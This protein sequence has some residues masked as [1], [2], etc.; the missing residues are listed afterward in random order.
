M[1]VIYSLRHLPRPPQGRFSYRY[2][3][4]RESTSGDNKTMNGALNTPGSLAVSL[5]ETFSAFQAKIDIFLSTEFGM[6]HLDT[7]VQKLHHQ[8]AKTQK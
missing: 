3:V 2:D 5:V 7:K 8:Q 4:G 1:K 6:S